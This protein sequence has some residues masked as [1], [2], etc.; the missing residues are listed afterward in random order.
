M[1]NNPSICWKCVH[2]KD[3]KM[4]NKNP[5]AIVKKCGRFLMKDSDKAIMEVLYKH[6][7]EGS[8]A[9]WN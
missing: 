9:E 6:F 8:N 5:N 7:I 1:S 2:Q 4:F 3:C